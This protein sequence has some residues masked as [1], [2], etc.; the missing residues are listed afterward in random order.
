MSA[1]EAI[2]PAMRRAER[3]K[4]RE[5]MRANA[6][7]RMRGVWQITLP[8]PVEDEP[9][10]WKPLQPGQ[11]QRPR[12]PYGQLRIVFDRTHE[13]RNRRALD[14]GP[15]VIKPG[16]PVR[17]KQADPA[18]DRAALGAGRIT[19]CEDYDS[20]LRPVVRAQCADVPRPCPFV[21]CQH[22][23]FLDVGDAGELVLNFPDIEPDQ[24]RSS[25]ALDIADRQDAAGRKLGPDGLARLQNLS[26]EKGRLTIIAAE[27]RFAAAWEALTGEHPPILDI[28]AEQQ[29][30]TPSAPEMGT[31]EDIEWT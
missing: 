15:L 19:W 21:S 18:H 13:H 10:R 30:E 24:M 31:V 1:A 22:H 7:A 6:W 8:L 14:V 23:L 20:A 5:R 2:T 27:R 16:E 29:R 12:P 9:E 4:R 3:Q 26:R 28:T 11:R 17:L 25:C